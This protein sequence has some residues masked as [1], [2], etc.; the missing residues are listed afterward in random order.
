MTDDEVIDQ[1]AT[2]MFELEGRGGGGDAWVV[3]G[4]AVKVSGGRATSNGVRP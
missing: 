4:A 2:E 3:A 1:A